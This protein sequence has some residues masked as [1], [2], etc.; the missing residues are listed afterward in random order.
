M[1]IFLTLVVA[2]MGVLSALYSSEIWSGMI[3]H[4]SVSAPITNSTKS[5]F[6]GFASFGIA[7]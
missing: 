4:D 2:V 3:K 5:L 6:F 1:K 7:L